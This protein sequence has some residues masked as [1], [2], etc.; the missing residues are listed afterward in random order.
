MKSVGREYAISE[1]C[2]F[3]AWFRKGVMASGFLKFKEG[4]M[5]PFLTWVL[6]LGMMA[7]PV[8]ARAAG[9]GDGGSAPAKSSANTSD[10]KSGTNANA[11]DGSAANSNAAAPANANGNTNATAPAAP[12]A[13]T[14]P[15]TPA[16][17]TVEDQLQQL[18]DLV[19]AQSQELAA[20]R[21]QIKQQQEK[22]QSLENQLK[23]AG[24]AAPTTAATPAVSAVTAPVAAAA[25]ATAAPAVAEAPKAA[26]VSSSRSSAEPSAAPAAAA[27]PAVATAQVSNETSPNPETSP[28][29]LKVGSAYITP[30][31]FMDFTGVWRARDGGSGIGTNFAGIPYGGSSAYQANEG[32]L[33]FSMQ[34]SRIGFRVDA[35]VKGS[36]VI[37]Y[38]EADFLGNAPTNLA[39]GSNSNT[40]RSRLYWVDVRKGPLELLGG[41][42]WSLATPNR[43]GVSPLPG[44]VFYS[45]NMD[46]N[47][48]VGM[49]WGRIPELRLVYH[50]PDD[51]AAFAVALDSPD[52]YMG[53]TNGST[54]ITLP[55]CCSYYGGGELDNGTTTLGP[56][57]RGPDVIAKFVAD[58]SKRLHFEIGGLARF[59]QLYNQKSAVHFSS[60]GGAGFVNLD[61]GLTKEFR[62]LTHNYWGD[63][64]GRYIFG[65][66]PD[67]I[68]RGDGSPSLLHAGSTVDGFELTHKN[69]TLFTYY[70]AIYI[71]R[72]IAVDTNGCFI[73]WG[74][75]PSPS[76][77]TGCAG[78]S[79]GQNRVIQEPTIGFINN[80]WKDGKYGALSLIGQYSYVS[81]DPWYVAPGSP[82]NGFSSMAFIDLR[83]TL[84]GSA[85]TL[86]KPGKE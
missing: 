34:N 11:N 54:G 72:N 73:G 70:G 35:D 62:F 67:M 24:S 39:V 15:A 1:R 33:R 36:H 25:P 66:A 4:Q 26:E 84:P 49:V 23:S 5:R 60:T 69:T 85:P 63:G 31:G 80:F 41:Q 19:N 28:L 57:N 16:S 56:P 30:V 82:K 43:V 27:T 81:R 68:I 48:Q 38:M 2:N 50:F 76:T 55:A 75:S 6:V 8:V 44:D 17:P 18:R 45:Y 32:E 53:G 12:A 64:G 47:Y 46:T 71:D 59:F 58:P 65:E 52:Q 22:M 40:L 10:A 14:A 20:T 79:S 86:G 9:N 29:Q 42:S 83:Y 21:E 77:L 37:G 61:L 74:Y 13:A 78:A 51:K 7:A 3:R